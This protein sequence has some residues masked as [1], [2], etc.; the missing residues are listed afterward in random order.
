MDEV[1]V[2]TLNFSDWQQYRDLRL[3][4]LKEEPHAYGSTYDDNAGRP[5]EFWMERLKEAA[6]EKTQWL[7]F[8]KLNNKLVG[9]AGAFAEKEIDNAHIIAVYVAPEARGKGIS[10]LLMKDLITK[11]KRNISVKK[12][13]V[14]V[15]PEQLAAY[16]LYKNSG[17][18][19]IKQYKMIL[20]DGK[21]HQII[22]LQMV[23]SE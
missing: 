1:K 13:T 18:A 9:M 19:E 22:Q 7:V 5:D 23:L 8:A 14:D 6:L 12:I 21:E 2:V 15:N 20:G 11:I 4:A 10:K 17:F 16:N 3:R